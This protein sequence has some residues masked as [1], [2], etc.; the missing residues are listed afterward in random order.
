MR[1]ALH[2]E[3]LAD[4]ARG[5]SV[6][7]HGQRYAAA[8][9]ADGG[10]T[11]GNKALARLGTG[12]KHKGNSRRDLHRHARR[13]YALLQRISAYTVSCNF[14]TKDGIGQCVRPVSLLLPHE[15]FATLFDLGLFF[16]TFG[17]DE[18]R[19]AYW[20]S[21]AEPWW[22]PS[23][24]AYTKV[25]ACPAKAVPLRTHGDDVACKKGLVRL[26][27]LVFT[28]AGVL[29]KLSTIHDV[30]L[31][32]GLLMQRLADDTVDQLVHAACWS[33]DVLATGCWPSA[34]HL[35]APL[36]GPRA[37]KHGPLAGGYFGICTQHL[38]DWKYIKE[39]CHLGRHYGSAMCCTYCDCR[40]VY[41]LGNFADFSVAGVAWFEEHAITS[42]DYMATLPAAGPPFLPRTYGFDLRMLL[43]DFMHSDMLGVGGWLLANALLDMAKAGRFGDYV[44]NQK[45]R[46]EQALSTAY[47][48]FVKFAKD[49]GITH[50]QKLF[51][52]SLLGVASSMA[53]PEF[54]G[55]AHNCSVVLRW[56]AA[57]VREH[58][59]PDRHGKVVDAC[60][61]AHWQY[62]RVMR[63]A[64]RQFTKRQARRFYVAGLLMLRCYSLL[65]RAAHLR[66][67]ARW[68]M[69]PKHHH[70]WHAFRHALDSRLNPR[71]H[72][73]YKHEDFM[74][75]ASA[76]GVHIHP[77][78]LSREL[79]AVWSLSWAM[80][81]PEQFNQKELKR[82]RCTRFARRLRGRKLRA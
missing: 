14:R 63:D 59:S 1:G 56:M 77:S 55:K 29:A 3:V 67:Q 33:I 10:E 80:R 48:L 70:L 32:F 25:M 74:G 4:I 31:V 54:K 21:L 44:G 6:P 75:I 72:W 46:L 78:S 40:K 64:G 15:F 79:L 26:S 71:S 2:D 23:H 62:H 13:E 30:I 24:P 82:K 36:T 69:K 5:R 7:T 28:F 50:S 52:L 45:S 35:H 12:G 61:I 37:L 22:T 27:M 18:D 57:F 49:N 41:G 58:P 43:V 81:V 34:D 38:G 76:I 17:S 11:P 60:L 73:L 42:N 9:V 65:S 19:V 20:N 51:T 47:G 39:V 53:W 8:A 16:D 66:R 68:Q